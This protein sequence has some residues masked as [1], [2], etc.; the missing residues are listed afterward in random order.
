MTYAWDEMVA[1]V[2][3]IHACTLLVGNEL[4]FATGRTR[5]GRV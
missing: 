4:K 5:L 2:T 3:C 1:V